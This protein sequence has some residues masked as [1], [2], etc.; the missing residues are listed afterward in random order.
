MGGNTAT[1]YFTDIEKFDIMAPR[2]TNYTILGAYLERVNVD[3]KSLINIGA[4]NDRL[5]FT[6]HCDVPSL[7][8]D[9]V[10]IYFVKKED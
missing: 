7:E 4:T 6:L 9:T 2:N 3:V 8:D 5:L 1:V 10:K